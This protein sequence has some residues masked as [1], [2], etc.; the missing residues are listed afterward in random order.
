MGEEIG[1]LGRPQLPRVPEAVVTDEPQDPAAVNPLRSRAKS[2]EAGLIV[3][4]L[5]EY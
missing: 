5:Q 2:L 1:Y 3:D 4:G